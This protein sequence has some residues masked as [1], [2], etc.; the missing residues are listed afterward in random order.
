MAG[1]LSWGAYLPSG[2]LARSAIADA[3]GLPDAKGTRS[4]CAQDEDSLTMAVEATLACIGEGPTDEID[5]IFFAS[6]TPPYAEK[7]ASATIAAVLDRQDVQTADFTGTVRA[8]TQALRAA[9]DA[10]RSGAARN[11]L[12]VAA[13]HRPAE[14]ATDME[15]AFG[16]G[17]AAVILTASGPIEAIAEASIADDITGSWRRID[18]RYVRSFQPR[19]EASYAYARPMASVIES[20][21]M[22]AEIG[23]DGATLVGSALN[24]RALS[25]LAKDTG[26]PGAHDPLLATVGNLGAAHPLVSLCAAL[27]VASESDVI[28][29]AAHGEGA[30]A[31]VFRVGTVAGSPFPVAAQ[32]ANHRML[33]SYEV[34]LRSHRFVPR[35]EPLHTSSVV[36]YWRDRRQALALEGVA[37]TVCGVVQFPANRACV[38]C[39]AFDRM[40]PVML[41]RRGRVFTFTMDHLSHGEYL[42]T[43]IPR[44]VVDL[45]SGG[46]IFLEMT[47]CDPADVHIGMDVELALRRIHDGAN[48]INYFW[49]ARPVR[50]S[51]IPQ[52]TEAV[53]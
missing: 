15:Q 44:L 9:L 2:R 41:A 20:A 45:H 51:A 7:H 42:Q 23:T 46:R 3:W 52:A 40:T 25:R 10:V 28:V 47:D 49:K 22:R 17:A 18:D 39:S 48:F 29:L 16:D 37:C 50:Q 31:I 35:E 12:V 19:H 6:T 8:G 24:G 14:P 30:D 4:V 43:P 33:P 5:A 32:I 13:D 11:C 1:I 38:E 36:A 27:D 21:V 26:F 34:L 53:T